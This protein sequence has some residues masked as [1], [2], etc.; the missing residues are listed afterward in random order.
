MTGT[1]SRLSIAP[2]HVGFTFATAIEPE[3][4]QILPPL[5]D[6]RGACHPGE[7]SRYAVCQTMIPHCRQ[8]YSTSK[9]NQMIGSLLLIRKRQITVNKVGDQTLQEINGICCGFG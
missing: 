7:G 5:W 4:G 1:T 6:G 8:R 9:T 3:V 2:R